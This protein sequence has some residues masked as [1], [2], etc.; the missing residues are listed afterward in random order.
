[1]G[2]RVTDIAVGAVIAAIVAAGV[3]Y[4]LRPAGV[5][6]PDSSSRPDH[7]EDVVKAKTI[8]CGY[9][10]YPPGLMKDANT[11][12]IHGIFPETLEASAKDL[13]YKI[14]WTEEVGWSTMIEGLRA[15][16][17]DAICSP[18]WASST[19]AQF[20]EFTTP[21]FYSGVGVYV[22]ADDHRFDGRL[23]AI[24]DKSVTLATIDGEMTSIVAAQDYPEART[25]ALP[26][27]ADVSQ[28]LL[29]VTS[30]KADVTFVEPFIAEQ[31]LKS[32][33]GALRNLAADAPVRVFPNTM[34]VA[35]GDYRLKGLLDVMIAEM[36][37]SG[38]EDR[39]IAKYD[40]GSGTFYPRA[41]PYRAPVPA[42]GP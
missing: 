34:M 19:R 4:G 1:M 20:A 27:N 9:V 8:R 25:V 36:V 12:R 15:G 21:L 28:A 22:R 17:Y 29:N 26:Q 40:V 31:F 13:G 7:Y 18:V 16:R 5:A 3:S 37:D 11:G 10:I 39:L 24:N 14:E 38:R 23:G 32:H 35:K 33:P 41:K 6:R 2:S 42:V 30:R